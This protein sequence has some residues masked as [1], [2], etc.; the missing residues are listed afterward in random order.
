MITGTAEEVLKILACE[1][2]AKLEQLSKLTP[3]DEF[4]AGQ[5]N[6]IAECIEMLAIW[7]DAAKHG[8]CENFE[9]KYNIE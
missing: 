6:A 5:M 1:L 3:R 7:N 4:C 2:P 8:L 9:K